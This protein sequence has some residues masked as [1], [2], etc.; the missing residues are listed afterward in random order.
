MSEVLTIK[1]IA[2]AR[3]IFY[4]QLNNDFAFFCI[5]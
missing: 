3:K 5:A 2:I 1:E 4:L